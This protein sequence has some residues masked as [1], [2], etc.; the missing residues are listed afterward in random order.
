[1]L[2]PS[3]QGLKHSIVTSFLLYKKNAGFFL[4]DRSRIVHDCP[5]NKFKFVT[6]ME[7]YLGYVMSI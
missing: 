5:N 7:T 6:F 3:P 4:N 2:D 1:M